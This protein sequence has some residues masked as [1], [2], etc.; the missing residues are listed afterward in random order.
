MELIFLLVAAVFGFSMRRM[1]ITPMFLVAAKKSRT[2]SSFSYSANEQACRS[3]EG[4][5]PR[6]YPKP[7]NGNTPYLRHHAQFM[8]GI[9]R[10]QEALS[11]SHFHEFKSSL[12][13]KFELF[14]GFSKILYFQVP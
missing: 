7:S 4:T 13:L 9:V 14:S 8:N 2:L 1:L 3:W 5:Q 6:S 10:G 11:S 12:V